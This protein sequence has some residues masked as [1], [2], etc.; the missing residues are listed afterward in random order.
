MSPCCKSLIY[1]CF[2]DLIDCDFNYCRYIA[3]LLYI[4]H[5]PSLNIFSAKVE[6]RVPEEKE[7]ADYGRGRKRL[8]D[9]GLARGEQLFHQSKGAFRHKTVFSINIKVILMCF[10][11]RPSKKLKGVKLAQA[12]FR[13]SSNSSS[14]DPSPASSDVESIDFK[15]FLDDESDGDSLSVLPSS[16]DNFLSPR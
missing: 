2:I 5:I 13:H 7:N 9:S 11:G 12:S 16:E 3:Q 15:S 6:E 4:V 1:R 8:G 14:F 10:A